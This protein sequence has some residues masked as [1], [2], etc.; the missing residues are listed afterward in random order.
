[1][2]ARVAAADIGDWEKKLLWS[3]TVRLMARGNFTK[4]CEYVP[5][6]FHERNQG[7]GAAL[8]TGFKAATGDMCL[9][10]C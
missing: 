4:I 10:R 9:S 8:G 3:K 1:M 7:K 5:R 2:F 6:Y